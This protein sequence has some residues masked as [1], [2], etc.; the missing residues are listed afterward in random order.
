M[1]DSHS[2]S[3]CP[4]CGH[5]WHPTGPAGSCDVRYMGERCAC[6]GVPHRR[7]RYRATLSG[8]SWAVGPTGT[9]RTIRA[10]RAWAE[11]YGDTAD[12]ATIT[13]SRG[14]VVALHA[15]DSAGDGLR[16]HRAEPGTD[17]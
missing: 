1:Q 12:V 14:R 3:D 10:A 7:D 11:S 2:L 8:S 4:H 9:F 6:R 13:D 16:W 15:R 5:P 17:R